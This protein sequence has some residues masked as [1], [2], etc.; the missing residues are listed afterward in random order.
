MKP[1]SQPN[2]KKE[3]NWKRIHSCGCKIHDFQEEHEEENSKGVSKFE[4][5]EEWVDCFFH[6]HYQAT[7]HHNRTHSRYLYI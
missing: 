7:Q 4:N 2:Q 1:E 6:K 5:N 3:R